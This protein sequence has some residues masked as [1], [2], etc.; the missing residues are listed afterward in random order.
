MAD[1]VENDFAEGG[2]DPV[3]EA[4]EKLVVR[5]NQTEGSTMGRSELHQAAYTGSIEELETLFANPENVANID[6]KSVSR[7]VKWDC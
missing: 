4:E 2:R 3:V 1:D 5:A 7:A 6:I